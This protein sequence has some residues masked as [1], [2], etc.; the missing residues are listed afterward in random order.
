MQISIN[1][2]APQD[3]LL[4]AQNFYSTQT[5]TKLANTLGRLLRHL[6]VRGEITLDELY[7]IISGRTVEQDNVVF[8]DLPDRGSA[9]IPD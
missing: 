3:V 9:P 1:G 7:N 2:G 6:Y 8:S 5:T 4:V